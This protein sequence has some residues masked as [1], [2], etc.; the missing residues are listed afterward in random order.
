ML[1]RLL[2]TLF[3]IVVLVPASCF[4]QT[5]AILKLANHTTA[6]STIEVSLQATTGYT[7][8]TST[9]AVCYN[10]SGFNSTNAAAALQPQLTSQLSSD[11]SLSLTEPKP[12][13]LFINI[14]KNLPAT[15]SELTAG[16]PLNIAQLQLTIADAAESSG[17]KVAEQELK[18]TVVFSVVPQLQQLEAASLNYLLRIAEPVLLATTA[19]AVDYGSAYSF[20]P[21]LQTQ[22][23]ANWA[24]VSG[25]LPPGLV[26]NASTG[27]V[28]GSPTSVGNYHFTVEASNLLGS[29]QQSYS[30]EVTKR[31]LLVELLPTTALQGVIPE[32]FRYRFVNVAPG[33]R[34]ELAFSTT[35]TTSSPLGEYATSVAVNEPAA[36][37][38]NYT[39]TTA[40]SSLYVVELTVPALT[41][42]ENTA[43]GTAFSIV[44]TNAARED[45]RFSVEDTDVFAVENG[46]LITTRSVNFEQ[47]PFIDF[48][49]IASGSSG[50]LRQQL[51]LTVTDVPEAPIALVPLNIE[52]AENTPIATPLAQFSATDPDGQLPLQYE[53]LTNEPF[54]LEGT[55][56]FATEILD[57]E[58]QS[59]YSFNV[60]VSDISG[61]SST[62]EVQLQVVNVNEAPTAIALSAT[63]FAEN[64]A[65][66][67]VVATF[68]ATD[69]DSSDVIFT[70]SISANS[71]FV[72]VNHQLVLNEPLNFETESSH[73]VTATATDAEGLSVS[74]DFAL[75]ILDVDEAPAPPAFSGSL[76]LEE[77]KEEVFLG[78]LFSADEEGDSVSFTLSG[79]FAAS[80]RISNDSLFAVAPFDFERNSR[81]ALTISAT[82]QSGNSS[83]SSFTFTVLNVNEA[84]ASIRLSTSTFSEQLAPNSIIGNLSATDPEGEAVSYSLMGSQ[85][86]FSLSGNR[87]ILAETVNFEATPQV[88]IQVRATDAAGN[89]ND[90]LLVLN[91]TD[92]PEAATALAVAPIA[93]SAPVGTLLPFQVTDPDAQGTHSYSLIGSNGPFAISDSSLVLTGPLNY[94]QQQ[95][96]VLTL[97]VDDTFGPTRTFTLQVNI[98]DINEAPTF[99]A[100]TRTVRVAE[101]AATV[102]TLTATDPEG[103]AVNYRLNTNEAFALT[104]NTLLATAELDFEAQSRYTIQ[105][106]A[107]DEDGLEAQQ[108]LVV[109]LIDVNEAPIAAAFA[110]LQTA[111][112]KPIGTAFGTLQATDPDAG[113]AVQISLL[114]NIEVPFRLSNDTLYTTEVLDY[115]QQS[116]YLLLLDLTDRG[117]LA[118][119]YSLELNIG[120]T[121]EQ[122]TNQLP[123]ALVLV[124]QTPVYLP[125]DAFTA[126]G[127]LVVTDTDH[128]SHSFSIRSSTYSS[129]FTI[130]NARLVAARNLPDYLPA[131][132]RL[133]VT[134]TDAAGGA[135]TKEIAVTTEKRRYFAVSGIAETASGATAERLL[136]QLWQVHPEGLVLYREQE[137]NSRRSFNF[138]RVPQEFSY[139]LSATPLAQ[140]DVLAPVFLGGSLWGKEAEQFSVAS[141]RNL[142]LQLPELMATA[143]GLAAISGTVYAY[144]GEQSAEEIRQNDILS[145]RHLY[146]LQQGQLVGIARTDSTGLFNFTDLAA[147]EYRLATSGAGYSAATG[148]QSIN[149]LNKQQLE[150]LYSLSDTQ[151]AV[152]TVGTT[153]GLPYQ[154]SVSLQLYPNPATDYVRLKGAA[155]T[156]KVQWRLFS[157][158]GQLQQHGELSSVNDI[159]PLKSLPRGTYL[160][161]VHFD[162]QSQT[163]KLVKE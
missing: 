124:Q 52:V 18:E 131:V 145:G 96:Y 35:A 91:V 60:L 36:F 137:L 155:F 72:V 95:Q 32:R 149:L 21:G 4:A 144:N 161:R 81:I 37:F 76:S 98:T 61:L 107:S 43:P 5:Q 55:E 83:Q 130:E 50:T 45:F 97:G 62:Y 49:L 42:A 71:P 10:N 135:V 115:E 77:N 3:S 101:N 119:E 122:S 100:A 142:Q 84:P 111:E 12:G 53:L 68:S 106:F 34:P 1:I 156:A 8:G 160:M 134:A 15:G 147:G 92:A 46:R 16:V 2:L 104:G 69:P 162:G 6:A 158:S 152:F 90:S 102:A 79:A 139:T 73:T 13:L 28:S 23:P 89:F 128:S 39:V 41:L 54:T 56:L 140:T 159:V 31:A 163:L 57:F 154:N 143:Q 78:E 29:S 118:I 112:N 14:V 129:F 64:T 24:I 30:M 87:L 67:E 133:T 94:E 33:D 110:P 132:V 63:E 148:A 82:D 86:T 123:T 127:Q 113:D 150:L 120:D 151:T 157:A 80:F 51:R 146:L 126:I 99:A 22:T 58:Q 141:A 103:S 114:N 66:G 70:Y 9:I 109:E 108:T 75:S 17:L 65:V 153:V 88:S 27:E 105:V 93:E 121:D 7:L 47:E 116:E 44:L 138:N 20:I 19:P 85:T 25:A 59:R 136:V 48:T 26:L 40:G 11:Y 38:D 74:A 117:G 125:A